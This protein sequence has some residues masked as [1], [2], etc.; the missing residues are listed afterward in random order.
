MR[1][2]TALGGLRRI[3]VSGFKSL[4]PAS[5]LGLLL[6]SSGC[7]SA[8]IAE[9]PLFASAGSK[10]VTSTAGVAPKEGKLIRVAQEDDIVEPLPARK[11]VTA[12]LGRAPYI[13]SPSGFGH[14]S[15]CFLRSS[16]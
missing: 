4:V 12:Y 15:R 10:A 1:S 8:G 16:L 7:S 2:L 11:R 3:T 5:F 9:S 14:T 6:V 13:C